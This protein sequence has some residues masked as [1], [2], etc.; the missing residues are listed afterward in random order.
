MN[1]NPEKKEN[2]KNHGL[3]CQLSFLSEI[4]RIPEKVWYETHQYLNWLSKIEWISLK[5][6]NQK[7]SY[8]GLDKSIQA[9]KKPVELSC[10]SPFKG[11]K[12][13]FSLL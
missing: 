5:L 10:D 8:T 7:Q 11:K 13:L 12:T 2:N 1:A 4:Q 9:K 3:S 6:K